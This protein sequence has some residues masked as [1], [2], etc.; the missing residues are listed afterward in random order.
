MIT[1][2]FY[3]K[4]SCLFR[5]ALFLFL[6][7][8]ILGSSQLLSAQTSSIWVTLTINPWGGPAPLTG[9]VFTANVY[10]TATGSIYYTFYCN[11]IDTGTNITPG[12]AYRTSVPINSETFTPPAGICDYV[13]ANPGVYLAKVI[14]ERGSAAAEERSTMFISTAPPAVPSVDIEA[15]P[16]GLGIYSDGPINISFNAGIDLQWTVTSADSCTAYDGWSGTKNT[17]GTESVANITSRRIFTL[18]CN[19]PGG[20][21]SD[22]VIVNVDQ[23]SFSVNLSANPSSGVAPLNGVV[24][25]AD[26]DGSAVGNINYTFYCD[27]SDSDTNI[28]PG[29]VHTS[30]NTSD[31]Y[32]APAGVCNGVYANAGTFTAKVIAER[33]GALDESRVTI[34]ISSPPPPP[35]TTP[36]TISNVQVTNITHNS[37]TIVWTTNEPATSQVRYG[38]TT[39]Y[40]QQTPE[41]SN[42]DT[43]HSIVLSSLQSSTTYHFQVISKDGA[44]NQAVS[45]D[46]VF[47]TEAIPTLSVVISANPSSGTAPLADVDLTAAV[48]GNVTGPVDYYF[49]CNRSDSGTNITAGYAAS[50]VDVSSINQTAN[51]ACDY[52]NAGTYT[53]KVIVDRGSLQAESRIS[54]LV[55]SPPPPA[56]FCGDGSC[57]GTET[58]SSCEQDCGVCPPRCG[59]GSCNGTETCSSCEQDCGVCLPTC[60]DGSCNG[61]ETCSSCEQ[62]C[63]V[64]LPTCGDGSCNG[65]ETCSSCSSDC[66]ICVSPPTPPFIRIENPLLQEDIKGVIDAVAGILRVIAVGIGVLM[67]IIAGIIIM[68][69]GGDRDKL[70]TGKRIFKWTIVGVAIV[71]AASFILE[72]IKELIPE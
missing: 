39:S 52:D 65:T 11:R 68:T 43:S 41:N 26:V 48:S 13:Y 7:I 23:P 50:Y 49:Y 46:F 42:L 10:G 29:Y 2:N 32:S 18:T 27:R 57:N 66:G 31:P 71:M 44:G 40:G 64:C 12:Y 35:D 37:A 60:G 25:T 36:P 63:G 28:A 5:F 58:C 45:T 55:K 62:D 16:T 1:F 8:L 51:N 33:S 53:A 30:T 20:T 61:T 4:F 67:I 19:G 15:R 14:V 59:D 22:S 47:T 34:N 9:V 3:N 69:S 56:P 72:L 17:S 21:S 70:E 54:I 38:I 24:L 6:F